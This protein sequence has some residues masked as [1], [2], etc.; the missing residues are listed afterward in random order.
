M[1]CGSSHQLRLEAECSEAAWL[2]RERRLLCVRDEV[3]AGAGARAC[4]DAAQRVG[5][6]RLESCCCRDKAWLRWCCR[7]CSGEEGLLLWI[8]FC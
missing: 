4:A 7:R 8:L 2:A 1:S 5:E 6:L 3:C